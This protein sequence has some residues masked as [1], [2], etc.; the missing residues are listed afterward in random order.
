MNFRITL[1]KKDKAKRTLTRNEGH[2]NLIPL[3]SMHSICMVFFHNLNAVNVQAGQ[4]LRFANNQFTD[5]AKEA[6]LIPR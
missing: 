6:P 4:I 2:G 3:H 5:Y 1:L